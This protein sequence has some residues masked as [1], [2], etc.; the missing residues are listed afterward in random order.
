M[1]FWLAHHTADELDRTY[2]LGRVHVCARC[3]GT[4]PTMFLVIAVQI[5]QRAPLEW[6]WDG[7]WAVGLL[8][9]GLVDWAIGR[10]RPHAG[11]NAWRTLSGM[12]I[13]LALGRT[14][15][16]HMVSPFPLW[17]G[18]Q[19]AVVAVVAVPVL[20]LSYRQRSGR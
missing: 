16:V 9:P 14:L 17:L 3:L 6:K 1:S 8:M 13:G 12:G 15:Y 10:F 11:S 7:P 19:A 5:S 20:A 18:V 2:R 4:Y